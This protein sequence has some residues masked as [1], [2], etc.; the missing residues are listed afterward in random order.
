MFPAIQSTKHF[1]DWVLADYNGYYMLGS[2]K[3]DKYGF[4]FWHLPDINS[5]RLDMFL[6]SSTKF[7]NL[8]QFLLSNF[9]LN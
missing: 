5:M 7:K 3:L 1:V 4:F 2:G 6:K 9:N 8:S